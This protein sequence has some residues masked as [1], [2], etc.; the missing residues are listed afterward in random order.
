MPKYKEPK[1]FMLG[2]RAY[3]AF[4]GEQPQIWFEDLGH[5]LQVRW[6]KVARAVLEEEKRIVGRTPRALLAAESSQIEEAEEELRRV[7][8]GVPRWKSGYLKMK[9]IPAHKREE[10]K[11]ARQRLRDLRRK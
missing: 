7:T 9:D 8:E 1:D 4:Y 5:D 3:E 10:I 2:R 11:V 6:S